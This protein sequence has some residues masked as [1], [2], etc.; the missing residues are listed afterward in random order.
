MQFKQNYNSKLKYLPSNILHRSDPKK[1]EVTEEFC[2]Q[3]HDAVTVASKKIK[4]GKKPKFVR[5]A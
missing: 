4:E 1:T 2:K 5:V 3:F